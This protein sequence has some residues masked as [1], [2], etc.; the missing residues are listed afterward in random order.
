MSLRARQREHTISVILDTAGRLFADQGFHGVSMEEIAHGVGC[1][2]ATLYGYF[3]G[4][5]ELINRL[6][7]ERFDDYLSGAEHAVETQP[8]FRPAL[9]AYVEHFITWGEQHEGIL[10]L[11]V[12]LF[13]AGDP[14]AIAQPEEKQAREARHLRLVLGLMQR[15]LDEGVLPQRPA[16]FYAISFI[17]LLHAHAITAT[18]GLQSEDRATLAR[19]ATH[20][21]FHG[22]FG[23]PPCPA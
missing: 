8:A 4:K 15:G 6:L 12:G 9:D 18:L 1:A 13:R 3:K 10:R 14:A 7:T 2:P 22:A 23:S 16:A 20:Q 11:M 21:F 5:N 17:A 19:A